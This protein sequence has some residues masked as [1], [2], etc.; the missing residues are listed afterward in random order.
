[1]KK[2]KLGFETKI[3]KRVNELVGLG[4]LSLMVNGLTVML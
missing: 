3:G 2:L 4:K 1:M